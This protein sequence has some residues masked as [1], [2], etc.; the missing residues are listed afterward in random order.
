M[1]RMVLTAW[2]T[3]HKRTTKVFD[4]LSD[5]QLLKEIAP[6]RNRGVYLLGHLTAVNDNLFKLFGL[7]EPSLP[8][9][10]DQFVKEADQ[11]EA[12]LPPIATLRK[13]WTDTGAALLK[14]MNTLTPEQW[15]D[16]HTA[17][18]AEDFAREPHRNKLNV[19]MTRIT[20]EGYHH[21]QLILLQPKEQA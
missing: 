4:S 14:A 6:G 12:A 20:H 18:S 9:F 7:G 17:V 21:G 15:F 19:L 1:V 10:Y 16:G 8:T 5:E 11:P 2:E 3:Q 13:Q